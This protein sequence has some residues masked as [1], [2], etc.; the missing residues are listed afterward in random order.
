[1]KKYLLSVLFAVSLSLLISNQVSA[2]TEKGDW[3]VGG[4]LELNTARNNTTIEFSPNA[5]YFFMKNLAIG[6][7]LLVAYEELGNL[8]ITSVGA[9]P[10]V[11]YYFSEGKIKPFFSGDIDYQ[12]RKLKTGQGSSTENAF[13]YFLGGGAAFFINNNVAVEGLLGYNHIMVKGESGNGGLNF[14][15]GFQVYINKNQVQGVKSTFTK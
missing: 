1:M 10:F 9:G 4:L 12:N 7:K 5:G 15:V 11:R 3:L 14:K 8:D 13:N 2:Q 6:A